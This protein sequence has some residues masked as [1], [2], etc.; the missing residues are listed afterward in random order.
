MSGSKGTLRKYFDSGPAA[1]ATTNVYSG[2]TTGFTSGIATPGTAPQ[3]WLSSL[4]EGATDNGRVGITIAVET[5]DLRVHINWD[6]LAVVGV[7]QA[8]RMI[9]LADNECDGIV[10]DQGDILLQPTVATGAVMSYL[11]PSYFGRFHIIED[12]VF[13]N[14][15]NG[16]LNQS[17]HELVHE[18]HHDLKGHR[19]QYATD[20]GSTITSARKGNLFMYFFYEQ[21]TVAAGG[22]ITIGTAN[23][24]GV[25]FVSR[26]RYR[27]A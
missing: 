8:L 5:L 27:D 7:S 18:S 10:P 9:V 16:G 23:P 19:I 24:P 17:A 15:Q 11:N 22:I 2:G 4:A 14:T 20:D 3:L 26:I 12:K 21:R 13:Y 1:I 25:Q 6:L